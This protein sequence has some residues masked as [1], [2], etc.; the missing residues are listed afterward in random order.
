MKVSDTC[1]R[2]MASRWRFPGE[3]RFR[4]GGASAWAFALIVMLLGLFHPGL[5][6]AEAA[7]KPALATNAPSA[8]NLVS[9]P[10]KNDEK[11]KL[12]VGDR[13]SLR[14][15][16]D[17]EEAKPLSVSDS[18]EIEVPYIGR[19]KVQDRTCAEVAAEIKSKLEVEYYYQATVVLSL[20]Q[21][22]RGRR[23]VYLTGYVRAAGPLDLPSD[24]VMTLSK[25]ILR[26]GGFQDF[27]DEKKVR[28]TR[29]GNTNDP[30]ATVIV[31]DV[32]AIIKEGRQERDIVLESGD[33]IYVPNRLF[34]F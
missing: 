33:I 18:G 31:I 5:M 12:G 17:Q 29:G 22:N 19:I 30:S 27:A 26:A 16:E 23:K 32:G 13:L 15:I 21:Y 7:E 20:D 6:A 10:A 3:G 9:A 1:V 2:T 11:I 24:E 8:T 14:V 28:V 34:K 4:A 25:A